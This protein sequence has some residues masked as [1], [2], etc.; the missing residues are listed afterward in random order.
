MSDAAGPFRLG[1]K[2]EQFLSAEIKAELEKQGLRLGTV[3][4][5]IVIGMKAVLERV[6]RVIEADGDRAGIR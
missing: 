5:I 2:P 3:I 4:Q 1:D 6:Q